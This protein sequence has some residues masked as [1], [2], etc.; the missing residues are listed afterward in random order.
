ML[1]YRNIYIK[2]V[3]VYDINTVSILKGDHGVQ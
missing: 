1:E 3:N 2:R